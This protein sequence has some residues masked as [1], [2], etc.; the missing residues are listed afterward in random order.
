MSPEIAG[1]EVSDAVEGEACLIFRFV[2]LQSSHERAT[3]KTLPPKPVLPVQITS[4]DVAQAFRFTAAEQHEIRREEI[5]GLESYNVANLD[6][7]PRPVLKVTGRKNFC[8]ACI[9]FCVG[10][11]PFLRMKYGSEGHA[12]CNLD[13]PGTSRCLLL[14]L[15]RRRQA[16]P[17]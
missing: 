3:E 1:G 9:Q 14:L 8:F 17:N 10:L 12:A 4:L 7:P 11:M 16:K 13:T 15:S 6:T 2:S 5:I